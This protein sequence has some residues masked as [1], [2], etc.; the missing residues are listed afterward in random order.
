[1]L[2]WRVNFDRISALPRCLAMLISRFRPRRTRYTATTHD[3]RLSPFTFSFIVTPHMRQKT[4]LIRVV[5]TLLLLSVAPATGAAQT[6][7]QSIGDS[8][9][10]GLRMLKDINDA[11]K[12][13][14]Y[15]PTFHGL[16]I[17]A[18]F[19]LAAE[20]IGEATTGG[21]VFGIVAQAVLDL[22]DSH[23]MFVPPARG[24][25]AVYGWRMLIFGDACYI[26]AVAPGS[27]AEAKGLKAGD[28]VL[29]VD[30]YEPTRDTLWKMYYYYY[31]LRPKS[32]VNV[33]V[34]TPAGETREA[35]VVTK[36]KK[37]NIYF[38]SGWINIDEH[39]PDVEDGLGPGP[40]YAEFGQDLIVCRLPSFEL[41]SSDV[42]KMLKKVAGHKA[43]VLDL[44]G[45]P[46]G[47]VSALERFAGYFFDREV[48]IAVVKGRKETTE[49]KAKPRAAGGFGGKL[50]VLVDS[51]SASASEIFARL[52][53]IENRGVVI[54]DHTLGRVMQ[55]RMYDLAA[56]G[57]PQGA[58]FYALSITTAD[59][60]MSDGQ[61][62]EGRGV[63]PDELL[64][65][66]VDDIR[67]GRDPVLARAAALADVQLTPEKAGELF[68]SKAK[69]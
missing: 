43:L 50:I 37:V 66:T 16:D 49:S 13:N 33:S 23:T 45:N 20:K 55:S 4:F 10:E 69:K 40:H 56:T 60:F 12:E 24:E 47:L 39:S 32:R 7:K 5:C 30:G 26:T 35:E 42:D 9:R 36:V 27:D 11:L 58:P 34:R 22:N 21:Q 15:D 1:M 14:Y 57:E 29:S 48:K 44:R 52:V 25:V 28:R 41:D 54:G 38:N 8:R 59:L 2:R 61:R 17:D 6:Y 62:L 53:Q 64:L 46:G 19:R 51:R 65:P 18:R 68:T 3:V 31:L 67:L 63:I